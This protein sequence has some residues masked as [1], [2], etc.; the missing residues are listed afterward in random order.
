MCY[1]KTLLLITKNCNKKNCY[2]YCYYTLKGLC[3]NSEKNGGID[4]AGSVPPHENPGRDPHLVP[5][6][7]LV[8]PHFNGDQCTCVACY[9]MRLYEYS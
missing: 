8:S 5:F 3:S 7:T 1:A 9:F 6:L 2:P 4:T